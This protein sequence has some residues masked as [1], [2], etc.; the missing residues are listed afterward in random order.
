ML[1]FALIAVSQTTGYGQKRS[2]AAKTRVAVAF[3]DEERLRDPAGRAKLET[4]SL[5]LK[6]VQEIAKR[7]F[8]DVEFRI[9]TRGELLYL[10]DGTGLNVQNVH[11]DL[12]YVLSVRGKKRRVLSGLQTEADF[13]C[14]AAAFFRRSS[15]ACPK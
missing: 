5:F 7:D 8:P 12:G 14:A 2:H 13:A 3:Y 10:P 1:V 15:A 11:P 9:L 6:K 4:F